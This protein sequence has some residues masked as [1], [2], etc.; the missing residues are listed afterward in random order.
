MQYIKLYCIKHTQLQCTRLFNVFIVI[1]TS[2]I[3][4]AIRYGQIIHT[5]TK[6]DIDTEDIFF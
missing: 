3:T 1:C 4:K 6:L 5:I 2:N